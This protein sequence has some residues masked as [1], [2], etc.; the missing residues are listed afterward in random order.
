MAAISQSD[1]Q[2]P[3][4]AVFLKSICDAVYNGKRHSIYETVDA[5]FCLHFTFTFSISYKPRDI[6]PFELYDISQME[7]TITIIQNQIEKIEKI[8][9][10]EKNKRNICA[11]LTKRMWFDRKM[12]KYY[13]SFALIFPFYIVNREK[14]DIIRAKILP[15]VSLIWGKYYMENVLHPFQDKV[16]FYGGVSNERYKPLLLYKIYDSKSFPRNYNDSGDYIANVFL[17]KSKHNPLFLSIYNDKI[18]LS[19]YLPL[20]LSVNFKDTL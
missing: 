7:Q 8:E 3:I 9:N 10:I 19:Y 15:I 6:I 5:T 12:S 14:F 16:L 2:M 11:A 18:D 13:H 20:F 1:S 4:N 17:H